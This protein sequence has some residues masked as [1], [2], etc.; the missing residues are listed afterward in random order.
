M[1]PLG[2]NALLAKAIQSKKDG[3][4]DVVK[5]A[6][7]LG[8]DVFAVSEKDQ[9]FNARIKYVPERNQFEI[10]V[11]SAHPG[12]RR[13][14]SIAHE[15]S[16]YALDPDKIMK[17]GAMNR[18]HAS[19]DRDEIEADTLAAEVLMPDELIDEYFSA[20][21]LD[22]TS[23]F[24]AE[25]IEKMAEHFYVSRAMAVQRL[26]EKGCQIPYLSFA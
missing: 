6:N 23:A 8:I 3:R 7:D 13:R 11:N 12:T 9:D 17:Q 10:Y 22:E 19:V 2:R 20:N 5:L 18:P 25:D 15:L 14:F 1:K 4:V 24:T 16:H 21:N 26:R